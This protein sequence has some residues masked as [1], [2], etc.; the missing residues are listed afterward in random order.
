MELALKGELIE[1]V[2]VLPHIHMVAV[3]VVALVGDVGDGAEALLV[4]AGEAVAQGLGGVPY[5]AKPMLVSFF[6]SS[7]AFRRRSITRRA[8]ACP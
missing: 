2:D 1:G 3:G 5:R 8:K 4:D 7:Q 6:Q